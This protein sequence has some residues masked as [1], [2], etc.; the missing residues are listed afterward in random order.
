MSIQLIRGNPLLNQSINEELT[1]DQ[2]HTGNDVEVA[3]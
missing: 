3:T 2:V 1:S